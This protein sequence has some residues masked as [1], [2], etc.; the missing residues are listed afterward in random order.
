MFDQAAIHADAI[1]QPDL[2]SR[3]KN[4][5]HLSAPDVPLNSKTEPYQA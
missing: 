5:F 3:I 4:F 1:E 2:L